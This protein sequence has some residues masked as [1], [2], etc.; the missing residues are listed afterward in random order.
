[1]TVMYR[2]WKAAL[3]RCATRPNCTPPLWRW[4]CTTEPKSNTQPYRTGT[5]ATRTA[6]AASATA[7]QNAHSAQGDDSKVSW[8]QVETGSAITWKYQA[9]YSGRQLGGRVLFGGSHQQLS[10]G[11]HGHQMIHLGRNTKSRIV[12]RE[13]RQDIA[14]T[15][16]A[17]R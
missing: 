7:S 13:Y 8:T 2:I 11:R 10:A 16:T 3:L 9:A 5:L 15:A 1:M 12:S 6:R 4:W 14:R 17:V